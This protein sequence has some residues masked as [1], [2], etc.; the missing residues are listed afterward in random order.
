MGREI[1][2]KREATL[3]QYRH[4]GYKTIVDLEIPVRKANCWLVALW[5]KNLAAP[6]RGLLAYYI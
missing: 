5:Q 2:L 6:T 1:E 4:S 3:K